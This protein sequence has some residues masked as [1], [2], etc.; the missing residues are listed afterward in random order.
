MVA[1]RWKNDRQNIGKRG[2]LV[3]A[4][5]ERTP[6]SQDKQATAALADELLNHAKLVVREEARF[7][8]TEDQAAIAEQFLTRP[9]ESAGQLLRV[10]DA[11]PQEFVVGRLF[12]EL[13]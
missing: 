2:A 8:T 4:A 3:A 10:L 1:D 9:R 5:L 7:H 13:M 12:L 11:E 6:A